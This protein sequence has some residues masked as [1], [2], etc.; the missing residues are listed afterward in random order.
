MNI[1]FGQYILLFLLA[2][3]LA[4][5]A[6]AKKETAK[7]GKPDPFAAYRA[8][9][10]FINGDLY[11]QS[12]NLDSAAVEYRKA[13]IL[14]PTSAEIRR[15]LSEIYF[16]QQRFDEAAILRSEIDPKTTDDFNFIGD[17]MRFSKDFENAAKF[18]ERSLELD[19]TQYVARLYYAR[20]LEYLGQNDKAEKE[21]KI[22]INF[23][24]SKTDALLD[25]AGFYLK[26]NKL[27]KGIGAYS[28]ASELDP[29]DIRPIIGMATV[30]LAKG[31]TLVADSLYMT[32]AKMNW[33][34][35]NALVSLI[36]WF[37]SIEDL[38]KS[39]ELAGRVAGLMPND[40][41]AQKRYAMILYGN[42]KFPQAESLF[43]MIIDQGD[44][45]AAVFFYMARMKQQTE[46][47]PAAEQ[48]FR[49]SLDFADTVTEAWINLAIVVDLQK[50]Y[51]DAID[52]MGQALMTVPEDSNAIL[53]YTAIIHGRNERYDLAKEGYERLLYS[54][55][56][57]IGLRFSIASSDERLGNI[58][59]AEQGFKW[60]INKDPKNAM[61]LN[62][63]GYMYADKGVKLKEA[64][65]LI[66]R[67][68]KIDPENGAYLDSYAWVLYK[69]GRYDEALVQM[70]K[71]VQTET[72]DPVVYDHQGDIYLALDK[73]DLARESWTKALELKPEDETIRNK[74]Y[75]R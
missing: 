69:L 47:Y 20:L 11:E 42:E 61:A 53:L 25:L 10:H 26:N 71:A 72:E 7:V 74:L 22:V 35:T 51:Q 64:R 60:V 63:L 19:S 58:D 34:D 9:D 70:K 31:D 29:Q 32:V 4:C 21:Y 57:D 36:P 52:I 24:P 5:G 75:P 62:Y 30:Y 28:Q 43:A 65:D 33:D 17:C 73:M 8:Y 55:P 68:L 46:D 56:E 49:K 13:L 27:D 23:A 40:L 50:R 12:G 38:D 15:N 1:K 45:D 16:Q 2:I 39:E 54:N 66:E 6:P 37:L 67:A 59:E 18:Y 14:D 48:Y 41:N 3:S 44:K